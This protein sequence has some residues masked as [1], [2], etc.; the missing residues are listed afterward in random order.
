MYKNLLVAVLTPL[1]SFGLKY[2]F[3]LLGVE[4]DAATFNAMVLAIVSSFVGLFIK[5][6]A[7]VKG[8]KGLL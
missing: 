4:I 3:G 8:V 5:D 7:A 2:V 6:V 1:V